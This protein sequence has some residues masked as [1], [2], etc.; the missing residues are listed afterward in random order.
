[1]TETQKTV[2]IY[3]VEAAELLDE[4]CKN[5][6]GPWAYADDRVVEVAKMLQMEEV[7]GTFNQVAR[8]VSNL[9][10]MIRDRP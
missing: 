8:D 2:G 3:L 4:I 9:E 5:S 1:M 7:I 10:T 6:T